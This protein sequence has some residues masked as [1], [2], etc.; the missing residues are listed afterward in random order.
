MSKSGTVSD[1]YH[2]FDELYEHRNFLF[3]N[4]MRCNPTLAWVSRT[5]SDGSE[6]EGW[7][8][9]GIELPTGQISYHLPDTLW[10]VACRCSGGV[11]GRAPWDGHTAEDVVKRLKALLAFGPGCGLNEGAAK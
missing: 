4:L 10:D 11:Y 9:A 5:H 8:I 2:T 1:G 7:F 6:I 3:L